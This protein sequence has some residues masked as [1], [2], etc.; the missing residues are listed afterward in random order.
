MNRSELR[1]IVN[2]R[3]HRRGWDISR[4]PGYHDS[5]DR[6]NT[7]L[8]SQRVDLVIDVG[9]NVGQYGHELRTYGYTGQIVSLEPMAAAFAQLDALAA[10]D[11]SWAT[12]RSAAGTAQ[13]EIIIHVAANSIS[14][15]ALS[16][17]DRHIQAAPESQFLSS[18]PAP[19]DRLDNLV[20]ALVSSSRAPFLK[21][22]TQGFEQAVLDGAREILPRC[23]G[24]E[25]ELSLVALYDGQLLWREQIEY[26][27]AN[28][29]QLVGMAPG[30]WDK[31]SGELLQVDGVFVRK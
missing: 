22:D 27:E 15:S 21:I 29:F 31:V 18:E 12:V 16:M 14:S 17:L 19:V 6:R 7:L 9:A 4:W 10:T 20:G 23:V 30:F 1:A 28:D 8:R 24:V 25:I 13:G 5:A 2:T 3:L 11:P 26:L